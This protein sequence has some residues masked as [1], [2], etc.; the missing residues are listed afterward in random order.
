MHCSVQTDLYPPL[1]TDTPTHVSIHT[2]TPRHTNH[3]IGL[4]SVKV[5]HTHK[6]QRERERG[7]PE[8][9]R[10][11]LLRMRVTH[12]THRNNIYRFPSPFACIPLRIPV[13]LTTVA[14]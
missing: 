2:H 11:L 9:N 13:A 4:N 3:F 5:Q 14:G 7:E 8:H 10:I 6:E 12:Y 1:N